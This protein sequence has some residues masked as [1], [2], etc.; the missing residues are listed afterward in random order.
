MDINELF[1]NWYKTEGVRYLVPKDV[2]WHEGYTRIAF[3]AGFNTAINEYIKSQERRLQIN[4][5]RLKQI[6]SVINKLK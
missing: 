1:N 3:E 5:R 4:E 2:H 6:K